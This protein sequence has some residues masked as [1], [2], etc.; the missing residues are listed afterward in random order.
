M[1][2]P[3]GPSIRTARPSPSIASSSS[4]SSSA[5]SRSRSTSEADAFGFGGRVARRGRDRVVAQELL[6]QGDERGAGRAA[7]LL[8]QQ[9]ADVLVDAQRLVDVA[10]RAQDLHQRGAGGLAERL[11]LHGGAGGLLGLGVRGAAELGAG[12]RPASR[13]PR[14]AGRRARRAGRRSTAPRGRAAGRPR[15]SRARPSAAS[16][17]SRGSDAS[18]ARRSSRGAT[19][20][21]IHASSGRISC[22]SE[23][24]SSTPGPSALRSRDSGGASSDS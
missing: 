17:A 12:A 5:T 8:A 16:H 19:S 15:R 24:P 10:A 6:V 18:R 14:R 20:Q 13:A 11:R 9:H 1:P 23:R 4:V 7:E 2:I 3:G 21:S 22:S